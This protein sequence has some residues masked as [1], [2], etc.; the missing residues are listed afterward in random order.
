MVLE[1]VVSSNVHAVF[2]YGGFDFMPEIYS[3]RHYIKLDWP[4]STLFSSFAV[5]MMKCCKCS[6]LG[7]ISS[8]LP[9]TVPPALGPERSHPL[10]HG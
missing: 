9:Q 10:D 1:V 7:W 4:G 6:A 2:Q 5:R 8:P 3:S